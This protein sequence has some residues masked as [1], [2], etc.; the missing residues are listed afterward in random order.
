MESNYKSLKKEE[1]ASKHYARNVRK[2]SKELEEMN[3]TKHRAEPNE[4]LY[5][6][7]NDLW[8]YRE[9]GHILQMLKYDIE[10]TRQGDVFTVE[11]GENERS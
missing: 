6:L 11:R 2:L 5:G 3:E 9:K 4:C 7:I 1:K 10:I 8:N